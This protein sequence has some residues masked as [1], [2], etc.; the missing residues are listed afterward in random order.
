MKKKK[1]LSFFLA[2]VMILGTISIPAVATEEIELGEIIELVEESD[3]AEVTEPAEDEV[4]LC[5]E[6][7]V[8]LLAATEF[9]VSCDYNSE[10]EGYGTTKFSNYA[11]A[12]AYAVANGKTNATIVVEKTNTLSGNTFDNNHKNY[13]RLAVV[14]K[15]GA[16]MGN[17][18]SKWDMTYPVTVEAGGT[19]TCAR[20]KNNS[21]SNIHIKN[22][23]TIGTEGSD[24]KAYCNLLSDSYQD[25]DIS[26]RFN[27]KVV[28]HN[29]VMEIQDLDAQG[30][31]T[32]TDSDIT[33]DGAFASATFF[34]TTLNDSNMNVKGIQITGGLSDF[35][36]GDS[37]QLGKVTLNGDSSINFEGGNVK[38]ASNV[39]VNGTSSIEA[40]ELTI[41]KNKTLTVNGESS[42][43]AATLTNN[44][45]IAAASGATVS[46]E[47]V[48]EESTGKVTPVCKIGAKGYSSVADALKAAKDAGMTDVT[49]TLVGNSTTSATTDSF[50]LYTE[51]QFDSVTFTQEDV[52]TP[53]YLDGI[54]T[55]S[56]TNNG[57][58]VFDGVN[59]IVNQYIFEGNVKLT[60][61]SVIK[62][63]TDS[64]CFHYY[65][66]TTVEPGSKLQG[67]IDETRGG[68]LVLDG[69]KTD[70]TYN[71]TPDMQDAILKI[72][73]SGDSITIKNG[74]FLKVN[75]AN[76]VG[77]L[78]VSANT[79]LNVYDSM[80]DTVQ[81]IDVSGTLNTDTESFIKTKKITGAGK[82]VID[83]SAFDGIDT[84]VISAD[85]TGFTGT[86][87]MTGNENVV[88]EK[89]ATGV[90]VKNPAAIN[91]YVAQ[92]TAVA[93]WTTIWGQLKIN[94]TESFCVD[95]YSG[96]T[97]L[98]KTSLVDTE[99][100]ILNGNNN[101]VTWHAF[102]NGS[103][104]WWN[105]E[106]EIKPDAELVPTNVKC[107]VDGD[108]FAVGAVQMNSPDDLNKVT[109]GELK[110]VNKVKVGDA[111]YDT[112]EKAAA[113][114]KAGDT[115]TLLANI[116]LDSTVTLPADITFNGNGKTVAGE[117]VAG[118]DLTFEGYTKVSKF[119][120][121]YDKPVITI[122]EGATLETTSGR[123]VIG[124]GATF[125]ITGTIDDAKTADVEDLTPSLIIPGASFTGNGVTFN[126]TNAYVKFTAYCSSKNSSAY[127]THTYNIT[128]SIWD[129]TG[130]FVF[131]A[132]T[133]GMDPTFN[134]NVKDSV[135]NSTSHIVFSATKG[136][137]VIDNSI[138]NKD[139]NQ[140]LEI[141]SNMIIK[142]GSV[143]YAKDAT[144][145]N[146]KKPGTLTVDNAT[147]IGGT[148]TYS[149]SD[150]GI[151]KLIL[152]NNAKVTLNK[153][154]K[155]DVTID[156]TSL[157]TTAQVSEPDTT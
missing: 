40:D 95:I 4:E 1:N 56:R 132:P 29:A 106:W 108:I 57:T 6:D 83:A 65:S 45:T 70:G 129:Q 36:G 52:S 69:G 77:R 27:G 91:A 104:S 134:L 93:G 139:N 119:N 42:V 102:V 128:N 46:A 96:D 24:K 37:N 75:A 97:Y 86:I 10:T 120:A 71:E 111:K 99:K 82:I 94:G 20:S 136:D 118:G 31:F 112:L 49:I 100:V 127:G 156:C 115:I 126:V 26:I 74:A 48:S 55:G 154:S 116:T 61:N 92:D 140:Q 67:I 144:S 101:D 15:D 131:S 72:S 2:I 79:S 66:N 125:N 13:S 147:Y 19:L 34:A 60:N 5:G 62:S 41:N 85:M 141:C 25:C 148:D 149:G 151:G 35:A 59:I 157:L 113:A 146:A 145:S 107:Y 130:S 110:G 58:F 122:G 30:T 78:T 76:E 133:S 121:G 51:K 50:F 123:M 32:A 63:A 138:V 142:N 21:I 18:L 88:L 81:W 54:Y 8:E 28:L 117:I 137:I 11:G 64:N 105:T 135:F 47:T 153:I 22:T 155:T 73:W 38:V 103:D 14:I 9:Y 80:V 124:H 53:Y 150:L 23:L 143:V 68:K 44:G 114:A 98:G 7:E 87:E 16:T 90:T 152:K 89:T 109:W 43:S 33:V 17:A 39:T 3:L 84:E 12:Y